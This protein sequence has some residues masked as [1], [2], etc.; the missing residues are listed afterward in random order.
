MCERSSY[1]LCFE[2]L[3]RFRILSKNHVVP[4]FRYDNPIVQIVEER[5]ELRSIGMAPR[6]KGARD[7]RTKQFHC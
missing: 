1:R 6:W 7:T 2:E 3:V 4:V 5:N